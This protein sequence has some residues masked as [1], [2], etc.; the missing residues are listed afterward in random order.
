MNG[1]VERRN[2]AESVKLKA[3]TTP[4]C[5]GRLRP[6]PKEI[7]LKSNVGIGEK[8]CQTLQTHL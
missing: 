7:A 1:T 6:T 2:R 5:V 3:N 8:H 4:R